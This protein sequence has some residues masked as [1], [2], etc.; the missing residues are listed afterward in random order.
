MLCSEPMQRRRSSAASTKGGGL[1]PPPFAV[2]FVL[3]LSTGHIL[4]L[5]RKTCALLRAKTSAL[6]RRK[7]CAALRARTCA[8][9]RAN[10]KEK[11]KEGKSQQVSFCRSAA[12]PVCTFV[13]HLLARV[14]P[15]ASELRVQNSD[16]ILL[17]SGL[18]K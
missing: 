2:S 4:L 17:N 8:L 14:Q 15:L 10:T 18:C 3:A 11:A 1:R 5:R 13:S 12:G 16:F 6:L 9:Y 7:T